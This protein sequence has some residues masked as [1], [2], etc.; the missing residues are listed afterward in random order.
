MSST[1]SVPF[2]SLRVGG[3]SGGDSATQPPRPSFLY[4]YDGIGLE[5]L[6]ESR[7]LRSVWDIVRLSSVL[8]A[9]LIRR[10]RQLDLDGYEEGINIS[11]KARKATSEVW[12]NIGLQ[13]QSTRRP[14]EKRT[15]RL[16]EE[17]ARMATTHRTTPIYVGVI[18]A[19]VVIGAVVCTLKVAAR[20]RRRGR[21]APTK[22]TALPP[23]APSP[24]QYGL[25]Q[26]H[27]PPPGAPPWHF[28][29]SPSYNANVP[30]SPQ[31]S[32]PPPPLSPPP[33]SLQARAYQ[34]S[35]QPQ[36]YHPPPPAAVPANRPSPSPPSP[37]HHRAPST[38]LS[39]S[40]PAAPAPVFPVPQ[41]RLSLPPPISRAHPQDQEQEQGQGQ[42]RYSPS[43]PPGVP[44]PIPVP[45]SAIPANQHQHQHQQNQQ[46]QQ[47][48]S[49]LTPSLMDRMREV[50]TLMLEI[51]RLEAREGSG[52]DP[53]D[54]DGTDA[55]SRRRRIEEMRRRVGE[56]SGVDVDVDRRDERGRSGEGLESVLVLGA[57]GGSTTGAGA[58]AGVG[59]EA[60]SNSEGRSETP[61][62]PPPAYAPSPP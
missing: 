60:R 10:L 25:P 19:A 23:A 36:A 49:A 41:M 28:A 24:V 5:T 2:H 27:A 6:D 43:S 47:P 42:E 22:M 35:Y 15:R 11:S 52:Y 46:N 37:T 62:G 39:S 21:D 18:I 3:D 59:A 34:V 4:V 13:D 55:E 7:A 48:P 1:V 33:S 32:S 26:P 17:K 51:H 29:P 50:Q 12:H 30:L 38:L 58:G 53:G 44:I 9:A 57:E 20:R 31:L 8:C 40:G 16:G 45:S 54:G 14:E 61:L 56:L